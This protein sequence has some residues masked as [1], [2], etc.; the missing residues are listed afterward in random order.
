VAV[1]VVVPLSENVANHVSVFQL[2]S[3]A[4]ASQDEDVA[5]EDEGETTIYFDAEEGTFVNAAGEE[6]RVDVEGEEEEELEDDD[7]DEE[8]EGGETPG[9][10]STAAAATATGAHTITSKS[11]VLAWCKNLGKQLLIQH[12]CSNTTTYHAAAYPSRTTRHLHT[13]CRRRRAEDTLARTKTPCLTRWRRWS[14][15]GR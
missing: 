14:R 11:A 7:E 12:V 4:M 1:V 15:G 3:S 10:T 6:I 8:D 2:A 5:E 13:I 9:A